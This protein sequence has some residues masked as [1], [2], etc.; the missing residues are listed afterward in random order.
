M[1][2]SS[3]LHPRAPAGA[4]TG[5]QF[6]AGGGPSKSST[7]AK[8]KKAAPKTKTAKLT[9]AKKTR[10]SKGRR[11]VTVKRGDTLSGIARRNHESLRQLKKDNPGLFSKAHKGG[12]LIFAG[13]KVKLKAKARPKVKTSVLHKAKAKPKAAPKT[14]STTTKKAAAPKAPKR[15]ASPMRR[16]AKRSVLRGV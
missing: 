5:G 13:N 3:A 14:R 16:P 10:S 7:K 9:A 11:T 8:P 4:A 1:A 2:W 12:N 6:A 15:A